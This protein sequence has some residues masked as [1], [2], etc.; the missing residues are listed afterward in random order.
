MDRWVV[1]ESS[2]CLKWP[3]LP[4]FIEPLASTQRQGR[5]QTLHTLACALIP[6]VTVNKNV[7]CQKTGNKEGT[8]FD[9][10]ELEVK[11]CDGG[12]SWQL[13]VKVETDNKPRQSSHSVTKDT[14]NR[15][16]ACLF[17]FLC[18]FLCGST[19]NSSLPPVRPYGNRKTADTF[20]SLQITY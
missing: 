11:E 7:F 1:Q 9:I 15:A 4:P 12:R 3:L 8:F 19:R 14:S 10:T 6:K 5:P 2:R 16:S 18:L 20:T 13:L 17:L